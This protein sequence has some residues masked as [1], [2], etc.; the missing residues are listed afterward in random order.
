MRDVV[1]E[2]AFE[3][4]A[5]ACDLYHGKSLLVIG[6]PGQQRMAMGSSAWPSV[7]PPPYQ[8][9]A[10]PSTPD[11]P[12]M[13][14][15]GRQRGEPTSQTLRSLRE[16]AFAV[17]AETMENRR[18]RAERKAV[19]DGGA[20]ADGQGTGCGAHAPPAAVSGEL[21]AAAAAAAARIEPEAEA[22]AAGQGSC[23]GLKRGQAEQSSGPGSP[24]AG[25]PAKRPAP[26]QQRQPPPIGG[27]MPL[28]VVGTPQEEEAEAGVA[29]LSLQA[30]PLQGIPQNVLVD[31]PA[32]AAPVA[33]PAKAVGDLGS[34]RARL[35]AALQKQ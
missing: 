33:P 28:P 9:R 6:R 31:S 23:S 17:A 26:E 3:V 35:L 19:R 24:A 10:C 11:P 32:A 7:A 30:T 2:E 21:A 18:R 12:G 4:A 14:Y 27:S 13:L 20:A 8:Q 16:A 1:G 34:L 22:A 29:A 25:T 15:S 5:A